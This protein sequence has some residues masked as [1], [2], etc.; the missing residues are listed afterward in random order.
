MPARMRDTFATHGLGPRHGAVLIQLFAARPLS[1]SELAERLGSSLPTVSEM[2]GDL[3]R[4]RLVRREVDSTNRRRTLVSLSEE[5]REDF[6]EFLAL[7]AAALLCALDQLTPEQ[8][9]GFVVGLR[10]WVTETQRGEGRADQVKARVKQTGERLK[11]A[12][13]GR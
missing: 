2:V 11:D 6:S 3:E 12:V 4:A 9:D 13:R 7:R 1:V 10:L 5:H 8:R